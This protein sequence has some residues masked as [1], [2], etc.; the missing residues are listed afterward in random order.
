MLS[1]FKQYIQQ[2]RA[3]PKLRIIRFKSPP[4][5][6][7]RGGAQ[8]HRSMERSATPPWKADTGNGSKIHLPKSVHAFRVEQSHA[9]QGKDEVRALDDFP[10]CHATRR[11]PGGRP[12]LREQSQHFSIICDDRT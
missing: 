7:H 4:P 12:R 6:F 8:H 3:R 5:F 2:R 1:P 9:G 10:I 11:D